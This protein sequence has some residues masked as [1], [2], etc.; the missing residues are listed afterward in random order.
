MIFSHVYADYCRGVKR[1]IWKSLKMSSQSWFHQKA[2]M[3]VM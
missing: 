1:K 2:R 3:W